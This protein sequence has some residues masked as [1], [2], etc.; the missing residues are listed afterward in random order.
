MNASPFAAM[1]PLSLFHSFFLSDF[2]SAATLCCHHQPKP[3]YFTY[4]IERGFLFSR[5]AA[6]ITLREGDRDTA[7]SARSKTAVRNC[8][9]H[10]F[11]PRGHIML[12]SSVTIRSLS[13]IR[14]FGVIFCPRGC[15]HCTRHPL[16]Q[17][18]LPLLHACMRCGRADFSEMEERCLLF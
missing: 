7:A 5:A 17:V 6:L 9:K 16:S 3:L 18:S 14:S 1:R 8:C 10:H 15:I 2:I 11:H 12:P 13:A 4:L